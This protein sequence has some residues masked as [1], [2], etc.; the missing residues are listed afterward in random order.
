MQILWNIMH[1][2]RTIEGI[3]CGALIEIRDIC[4]ERMR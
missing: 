4:E 3:L 1:P 2:V